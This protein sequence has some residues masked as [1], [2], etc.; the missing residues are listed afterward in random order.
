MIRVNIHGKLGQEIGE[1]WDLDVVS[2]S[3]ALRAIEANT[4]KLRK[5][6]L[7]N[8]EV[9]EYEILINKENLFNEVPKFETIEDFKNS[10]FFLDISEKVDTIDIIP[11]IIGSIGFLKRA[12]G[13]FLGGLSIAAAIFIPFVAPVLAFAAPGLLFAGIGLVAAGVSSLLS[14][15]PPNVPFTAQ[16]ADAIDGSAGGPSSY[17]FNGPNNTVGEGGPVP[18]GYGE[19]IVG[20]HNIM[21]NFSYNVNASKSSVNSTTKQVSLY[22]TPAYVFNNR[23]FL[24]NQAPSTT[25]V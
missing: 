22:A 12:A 6:L 13:I 7:E 11:E 1:F 3:E 17:L 8:K 18:V 4:G 24:I 16:Q 9:F 15:P 23:G 19:L 10:E 5:F 25:E 20:G 2:V 14:K 21:S